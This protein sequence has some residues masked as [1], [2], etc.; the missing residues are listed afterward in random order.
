MKRRS[1]ADKIGDCYMAFKC[2]KAGVK[3]ERDG[4]KDGSIPTHPVVSVDEVKSEADVLKDCTAWLKH[5]GILCDRNNVGA[6]IMSSSGMHSY[7]IKNGG[8]IIGLFLNGIHFEVECKRGAGGRL[9][10]GQQERMKNVRDNRGYYFVVHG[11]PELKYFMEGLMN[12]IS[13]DTNG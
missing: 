4:A 5:H 9:S 11:I 13:R 1:K 3:V 12:I 7:G 10:R 2:I 8:D 6:G